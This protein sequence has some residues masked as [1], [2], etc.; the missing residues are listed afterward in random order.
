MIRLTKENSKVGMK[1]MI[2]SHI[3]LKNHY[4][5]ITEV[6]YVDYYGKVHYN[7]VKVKW[8]DDFQSGDCVWFDQEWFIIDADESLVKKKSCQVCNRDNNSN[9]V[10]CWWC[11]NQP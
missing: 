10:S 9:S 7:N 8:T 1:V 2:N 3:D 6:P 5:I 11:G 4:A